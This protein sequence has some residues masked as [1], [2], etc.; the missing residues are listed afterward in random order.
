MGGEVRAYLSGMI[1]K[2]IFKSLMRKKNYF[3]VKE[4]TWRKLYEVV[5]KWKIFVLCEEVFPR[6]VKRSFSLEIF[7]AEGLLKNY[8]KRY[9]FLKNV[10]VAHRATINTRKYLNW[11]NWKE[12]TNRLSLRMVMLSL[13][14]LMS[15]I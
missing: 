12:E 3:E 8:R 6:K 15:L 10:K 14:Q 5:I 11:W 2:R 1:S 9:A 4:W 7:V 13:F